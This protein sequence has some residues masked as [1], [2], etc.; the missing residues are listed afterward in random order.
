M[1]ST[2]LR[3]AFSCGPMP[4]PPKTAA[5]ADLRVLAE[6]VE[7]L[8]DLR[9]QLARGGEDQGAGGAARLAEQPLQDRQHEGGGLA[10]A[11]HGA[12]QHVAAVEA[13]RDGVALDRG[14]LGEAEVG[15]AAEQTGIEIERGKT[16]QDVGV[17]SERRVEATSR[18]IRLD[19]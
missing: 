7:V 5:A 13:G 10:A 18:A 15:D 8:D 4:T 2:P 17:L 19:S 16:H 3:K 6:L 12:G 9:R 1:T 11:R 14:R